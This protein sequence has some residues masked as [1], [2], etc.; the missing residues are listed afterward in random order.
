[1]VH[2]NFRTRR[3][4]ERWHGLALA[5]FLICVAHSFDT[6]AVWPSLFRLQFLPMRP[7]NQGVKPASAKREVREELQ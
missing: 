5:E 1:M 7:L 4:L 2:Q 6:N 3:I